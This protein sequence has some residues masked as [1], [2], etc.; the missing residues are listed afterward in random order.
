MNL[1]GNLSYGVFIN[2]LTNDPGYSG[3]N[4]DQ[5]VPNYSRARFV[6]TPRTY[7]LMLR[8]HF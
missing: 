2:N 5:T 1:T 8:Y 3:G 7:G 4:N 6:I